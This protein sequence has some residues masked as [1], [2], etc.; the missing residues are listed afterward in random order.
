MKLIIFKEKQFTDI[1]DDNFT[2]V[3]SFLTIERY[4]KF[5]ELVVK[6]FTNDEILQQKKNVKDKILHNNI[7]HLLRIYSLMIEGIPYYVQ[8]VSPLINR[9]L[10]ASQFLPHLP[11]YKSDGTVKQLSSKFGI[12][13]LTIQMLSLILENK[14]SFLSFLKFIFLIESHY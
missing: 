8:N 13:S 12:F 11:R 5:I 10:I 1:N 3:K 4:P 7:E 9:R 6:V 2:R 14:L